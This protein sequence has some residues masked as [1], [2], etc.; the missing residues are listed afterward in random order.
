MQEVR[1]SC[2]YRLRLQSRERPL[3]SFGEKIDA[4][5]KSNAREG[6]IPASHAAMESNRHNLDRATVDDF[7]REW[8]RFDQSS[9]SSAEV[10]R[11]FGEYFA[12]FRGTVCRAM[13]S[14]STRAAAA[15]GGPHWSRR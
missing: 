2:R 5:L 11:R 15:G 8:Q 7:G 1:D 10:R 9:V 6:G 3:L 4:M 13:P 12:L 14:A